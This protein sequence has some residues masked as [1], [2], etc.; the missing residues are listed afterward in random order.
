M[1]E[2]LRKIIN[3][4]KHIPFAPDLVVEVISPNNRPDRGRGESAGVADGGIK[5][6]VGG[7]PDHEDRHR[8]SPGRRARHPHAKI[9]TLTAAKFSLASYAGSACSFL[10]F[11]IT[12]H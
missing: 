3:P 2:R 9:K 7:G 8:S 1:T 4:D 10:E 12:S 6:G 11:F 5:G